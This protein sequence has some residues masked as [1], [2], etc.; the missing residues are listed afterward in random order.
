MT[1]L[2]KT[3]SLRQAVLEAG[4][5]QLDSPAFWL[6][7]RCL[8]PGGSGLKLAFFPFQMNRRMKAWRQR[9][10]WSQCGEALPLCGIVTRVPSAWAFPTIE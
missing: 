6:S 5:A 10:R 2:G 4:R 7:R 1:D 8:L 3:G 9:A